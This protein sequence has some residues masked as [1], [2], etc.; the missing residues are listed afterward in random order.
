[1]SRKSSCLILQDGTVFPG[2][3]FGHPA[4]LA[5]ELVKGNHDRKAAGEVLFNTGMTGYHEVLT[6]PS[7]T[8]Q[9]LVMTYPHLGNYGALDEW[10]EIG[11]EVG[12]DR[13]GVK[14]AGIVARSYYEGPVPAGRITLEAFLQKHRTPGITGVDTRALTL[15]L[16]DRGSQNGVIISLDSDE[17]APTE[18]ELALALS[19][20]QAFPSMVGCNLIDEVGTVLPST[21]NKGGSPRFAVVDCGVKANI[22]RELV[23]RGCQ[24]TIVP[25]GT[26]SSELLSMDVDAVLFSNGPGDPAVLHETIA[27]I[28]ELIGKKPVFGIC[29]GHQMIAHALGGQTYKMKFGHHGV[30]HPVRDE[31]TGKV[32]VTSQ[33]HG[34]AVDESKLPSEVGIWFRNAN[35]G[36][37]EGLYHKTLVVKCAQFHPESAPGPHDS[38]WIFQSFIDAIPSRK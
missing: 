36:T 16:R 33:N 18:K 37:V 12:V 7:Y 2:K 25:D 8:G 23:K 38:S 6:D 5:S 17:A 34:F 26:S 20:L 15:T 31:L 14:C 24:V 30:N 13:M 1:M 28:R 32:F 4:P 22:V 21:E 3:S 35:D 19:Y 11:P 27:L 29:L 10:S 9:I